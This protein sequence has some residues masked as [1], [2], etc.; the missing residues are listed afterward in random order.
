MIPRLA[1]FDARAPALTIRASRRD[2][3]VG[4][5]TPAWRGGHAALCMRPSPSLV[6]RNGGRGERAHDASGMR[7][8]SVGGNPAAAA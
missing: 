6:A 1:R 8:A 7:F 3:R 2:D 4:P 5:P